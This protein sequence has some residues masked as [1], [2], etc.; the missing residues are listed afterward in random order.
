M[1][2]DRTGQCA[3]QGQSI[4]IHTP[5]MGSDVLLYRL[6]GGK[7]IS[8][9]T[10]RMGSDVTGN[11][12]RRTYAFQSTLPAWGVTYKGLIPAIRPLF[13]STLPAWGVTLYT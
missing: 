10:P 9:H 11:G 1:G 6:D 2:S 7:K 8:I 4:S 13:Q 12:Q 5:R 3:G